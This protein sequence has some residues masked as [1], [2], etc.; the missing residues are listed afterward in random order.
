[1]L[2]DEQIK[3]RLNA[4][5]VHPPCDGWCHVVSELRKGRIYYVKERTGPGYDN[6]DRMCFV[7]EGA[8]RIIKAKKVKKL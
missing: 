4:L 5:G 7:E 1:M 6:R 3:E 2:T 8:P